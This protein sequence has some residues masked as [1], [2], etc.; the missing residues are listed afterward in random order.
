MG[1]FIIIAIIIFLVLVVLSVCAYPFICASVVINCKRYKEIVTGV[2]LIVTIAFY[3]FACTNLE[4]AFDNWCYSVYAGIV[5][6]P[7]VLYLCTG[8]EE[9]LKWVENGGTPLHQNIVIPLITF[10]TSSLFAIEG[11]LRMAHSFSAYKMI[12]YGW[13][14]TDDSWWYYYEEFHYAGCLLFFV[15]LISALFIGISFFSGYKAYRHKLIVEE[16]KKSR[17]EGEI[18]SVTQ[19]LKIDDALLMAFDTHQRDEAVVYYNT[20]C[21]AIITALESSDERTGYSFEY[22]SFNDISTSYNVLLIKNRNKSFYFY[23]MGIVIKNF[24]N[25]YKYIPIGSTTVSLKT[26]RKSISNALPSD[27]HP[28]RQ[29]WLHSCRDGSPDLRYKY[30]PK[31]YVYEYCFLSIAE[32]MLHVYRI[33]S[34]KDVMCAYN[35]MYSYIT[36]IKTKLQN[37]IMSVSSTEKVATSN[38][39]QDKKN[40]NNVQQVYDVIKKPNQYI[41]GNSQETLEECFCDIILKRGTDILKDNSIL[42]IM[43][44]LYKD[45]DMSEYKNVITVMTKENF[46]YQFVEPSKMNDFTLYNLSSSF[47]NKQKINSQKCIFVTQAL[48]NALKKVKHIKQEIQQH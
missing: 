18:N 23:P 40:N 17:I 8:L 13:G 4:H 26:E 43:C 36:Q 9:P 35:K 34:A 31:T 3:L 19:R 12:N 46:L 45:L 33:K 7:I 2:L 38:D 39:V 11:C 44:S 25:I 22:S 28:I 16:E 41:A 42:S 37:D 15:S 10:L 27:V 20:L 14:N 48:V 32:L 30:N 1:P 6:T 5:L 29:F 21:K 47:A 24:D